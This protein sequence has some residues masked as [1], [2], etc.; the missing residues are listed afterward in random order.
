MSDYSGS[1]AN[2]LLLFP[3]VTAMLAR[4]CFEAHGAHSELLILFMSLST[5]HNLPAIDP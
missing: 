4:L 5:S 1:R 3:Q 2:P